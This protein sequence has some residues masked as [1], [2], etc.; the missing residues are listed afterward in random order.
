MSTEPQDK[1]RVRDAASMRAL[2]HPAR[3][4]SMSHLSSVGPAT[5]TEL[6]EVAGLTPSAMSYHL[7]ALERA[8]LISTA[9]SRGDGR[10]R[11]WQSNFADGWTVESFGDGTADTRAASLELMETVLAMQ[12][13][14]VRQ[15]LGRADEPGWLDTG[16]FINTV[17]VVTQEEL[18]EIG[19]KISGV[20]APYGSR[21]RKDPPTEAV[22]M[23]ASFRGFP[24][25]DILPK[26]D[27][28]E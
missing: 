25:D 16:F 3:I 20:L 21:E 8:G 4:K 23:R 10:E 22:K 11:V 28:K 13:I 6:G 1:M 24:S 15:W 9:P 17:I 27:V 7:R 14:E 19:K 18:L 12:D 2:A 5:A 26:G